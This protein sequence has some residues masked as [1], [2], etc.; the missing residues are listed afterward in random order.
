MH[1]V[2]GRLSADKDLE[3]LGWIYAKAFM[4]S[5]SD[6]MVSPFIYVYAI[7]LGASTGEVGWMRSLNNLF[8][9]SL[10]VPWG[11]LA[12]KIGSRVTVIVFTGIAASLLWVP[13]ALTSDSK[14]LFLLLSLHFLIAS[15]SI[16][17]WN[18]LLRSI[19]PAPVRG[20]V[21]STVNLASLFGGLIATAISGPLM[22]LYGGSLLLP[23][24]IAAASGSAG[25][26]LLSRVNEP[27]LK[28]RVGFEDLFSLFKLSETPKLLSENPDFKLFLEL[29]ALQGFFLT[30]A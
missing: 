25:S 18:A 15:A 16:P 26:L 29:T 22:D 5:L 2:C 1:P 27:K 12:D 23:V 19:V 13:V 20:S 4:S 14:A 17:A 24:T 28:R 3:G 9:Y 6:G 8:N 11:R 21:L 30:F 10:Q 7:R